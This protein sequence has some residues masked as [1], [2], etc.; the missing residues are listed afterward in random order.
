MV[1]N[2]CVC[3]FIY[4]FFFF[5]CLTRLQATSRSRR[6]YQLA[7]TLF[8]YYEELIQFCK[9]TAT[10]KSTL[11]LSPISRLPQSQDLSKNLPIS[12]TDNMINKTPNKCMESIVNNG[13]TTN[14][15]FAWELKPIFENQL[16]W[17]KNEI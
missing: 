4:S 5:A 12:A 13:N 7:H 3:R 11:C 16:P 17:E 10:V 9:Q 15:I 14:I 8:N 1:L 2:T 6:I